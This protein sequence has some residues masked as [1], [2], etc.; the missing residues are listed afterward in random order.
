[1]SASGQ[2]I[3]TKNLVQENIKE[4]QIKLLIKWVNKNE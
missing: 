1:M 3:D 4:E 2:A